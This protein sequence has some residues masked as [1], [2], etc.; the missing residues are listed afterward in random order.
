MR[1]KSCMFIPF[2]SFYWISIIFPS[3]IIS[4]FARLTSF[5]LIFL[6]DSSPPFLVYQAFPFSFFELFFLCFYEKYNTSYLVSGYMYMH[7]LLHSLSVNQWDRPFAPL[8]QDISKMTV[9]PFISGHIWDDCFPLFQ[10]ISELT[11]FPFILEYL[12]VGVF[13]FI[14][15]YLWV[16]QFFLHFWVDFFFPLYQ[17]ISEFSPLFHGISV[18]TVFPLIS[19]YFCVERFYFSFRV[20]VK[21]WRTRRSKRCTPRSSPCVTRTSSTIGTQEGR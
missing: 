10:D 9:F 13:P 16:D 8:S 5:S 7:D 4:W 11:F 2:F 12:L 3:F 6:G 14:S 21:A 19:W 15:G 1:L 18:L 20:S 17:G